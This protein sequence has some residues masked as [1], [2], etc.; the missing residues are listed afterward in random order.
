MLQPLH[1]P[2]LS[3]HDTITTSIPC[4][5]SIKVR[6]VKNTLRKITT[7]IPYLLKPPFRSRR[8]RTQCQEFPLG[9]VASLR[10]LLNAFMEDLDLDQRLL[11]RLDRFACIICCTGI[12]GSTALSD[13]PIVPVLQP[14]GT[15]VMCTM[16][17]IDPCPC[18]A[19]GQSLL[20]GPSQCRRSARCCYLTRFFLH[21]HTAQFF[22]FICNL[23]SSFRTRAEALQ[24]L[25]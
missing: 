3:S 10:G 24:T 6:K 2:L 25:A 5:C 18:P 21:S 15:L 7:T 4:I 8:H 12:G 19:A 13:L 22:Y 9:T 20:P 14:R 23:I 17:L 1:R 11:L 16:S